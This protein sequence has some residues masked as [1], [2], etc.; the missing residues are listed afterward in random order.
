MVHTKSLII[1]STTHLNRIYSGPEDRIVVL[2]C[3]PVLRPVGVGK[4]GAI[5][6]QD[7]KSGGKF[8]QEAE[9]LKGSEDNNVQQNS[10]NKNTLQPRNNNSW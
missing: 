4:I 2:Y 3:T 5:L 8:L 9:G 1:S 10:L 7:V 6:L